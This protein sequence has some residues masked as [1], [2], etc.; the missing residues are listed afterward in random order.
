MIP[1]TV[2]VIHAV[3]SQSLLLKMFI[4]LIPVF[5]A[6]AMVGEMYI[7]CLNNWKCDSI[8]DSWILKIYSFYLQI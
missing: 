2:C 1:V 3:I 8:S 6:A 7:N 5:Y 4:V